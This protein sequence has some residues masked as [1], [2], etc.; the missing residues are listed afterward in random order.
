MFERF[1][2]LGFYGFYRDIHIRGD[3]F[4]RTILHTAF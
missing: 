4:V 2:Y 3:F 1:G